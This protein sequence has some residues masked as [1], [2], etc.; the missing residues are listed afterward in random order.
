MKPTLLARR[1]GLAA[2]LAL[3][4]GAGGA[5]RAGDQAAALDVFRA[6]NDNTSAVYQDAK[7][8]FLAAADPVL[9]VGYDSGS[10][11]GVLV[12]HGGETTHLGLTPPAYHVL[13]AVG[14]VPRTLWAALRPATEGLDPDAT[15]HAKLAEL[16]PHVVAAQAALPDAGLSPQAAAR[17][18]RMLETCLGLIDFHLAQDQLDLARLQAELR[19][20]APTILADAAEAARLQLDA[21]DADLRPWWAGLPEEERASAY[22]L[23][24]G[25]KTPREGNLAYTY[26]VDLVGREE[27]GRRVVYAEG[28]FDEAAA[29]RLLA[30]LATD[31]RLSTDFFADE[32]RMERDILADGAE[33][34]VMELFGRLGKP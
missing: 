4:T 17:D 14:H 22:V 11:D 31:R 5:A 29:D 16:R 30:T 12:R 24:L 6:L 18:A 10:F 1:L 19:A 26:F 8:R 33:E 34:R 7:R 32:R 20:I 9:L 3:A 27:A 28:A 23:V 2:A 13:K 21:L 15:W 25:P